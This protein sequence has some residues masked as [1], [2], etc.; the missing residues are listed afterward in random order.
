[1][2]ISPNEIFAIAGAVI[3]SIGGGAL[4]VAA[5]ANWLAGIWANR[6]LQN[7]RAKHAEKL[8]S[9]KLELDVLK[10]K[11]VTRHQDKLNAYRDVISILSEILRELEA[12]A[13][14]KQ[15]TISNE[16]EIY[17]SKNR[18]KA[19]GYISLVS[20]QEVMDQFN[21][22]FDFLIPIIYE[23]KEGSWVDMR[24]KADAM[25]NAMRRDLGVNDGDIVY[26]GAR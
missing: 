16:A 15:K 26:R 10:Q 19:Y 8:E 13:I 21:D 1:M 18:T 4:I 3:T 25:L 11:N 5:C 20:N 9:I 17:F 24:R 12:V 22:L 7:E 14:G 2:N 23:G 6:M